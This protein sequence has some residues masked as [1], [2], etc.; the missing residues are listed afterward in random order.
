MKSLKEE[1]QANKKEPFRVKDPGGLRKGVIS[2]GHAPAEGEVRRPEG[3]H[4]GHRVSHLLLVAQVEVGIVG[5]LESQHVRRVVPKDL[6]PQLA[7]SGEVP[8]GREGSSA[9]VSTRPHALGGG[10][11]EGGVSGRLP[12]LP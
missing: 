2:G 12:G 10:G 11:Q 6:L 1:D 3:V 9:R 5:E 7:G 4:P 8:G